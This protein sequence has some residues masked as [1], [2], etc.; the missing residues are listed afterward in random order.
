M[1]ADPSTEPKTAAAAESD[2]ERSSQPSDHTTVGAG[3]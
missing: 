2:P 1:N 3:F